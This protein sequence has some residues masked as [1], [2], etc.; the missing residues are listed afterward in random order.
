MK[1]VRTGIGGGGGGVGHNADGAN[2]YAG[3]DNDA[4]NDVN[5]TTKTNAEMLLMMMIET[6]AKKYQLPPY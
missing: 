1:E 4:C 6:I 5:N 2:A 3:S